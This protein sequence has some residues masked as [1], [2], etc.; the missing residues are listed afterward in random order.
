ME[1]ICSRCGKPFNLDDKP[2]KSVD[3]NGNPL[4]IDLCSMCEWDNA[5]EEVAKFK[6]F[7]RK[8]A[9]KYIFDTMNEALDSTTSNKKSITNN[10][11]KKQGFKYA[12]DFKYTSAEIIPNA[13]VK[14]VEDNEIRTD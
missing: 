7:S 11:I 12:S 4:R 1:K 6:H 5:V 8:E 2:I 3:T 9:E 10:R 14:V 13:V